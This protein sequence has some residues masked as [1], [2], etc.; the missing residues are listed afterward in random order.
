MSIMATMSVKLFYVRYF[1]CF[2]SIVSES[3]K[4]NIFICT[5]AK[6]MLVARAVRKSTP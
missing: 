4:A 6:K 5:R 1:Y 3:E 2:G